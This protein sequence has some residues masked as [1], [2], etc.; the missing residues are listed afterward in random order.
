MENGHTNVIKETV[1]AF[2]IL[3]MGIYMLCCSLHTTAR[4]LVQKIIIIEF[5]FGVNVNT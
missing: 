2:S 3:K 1:A 5:V 4:F